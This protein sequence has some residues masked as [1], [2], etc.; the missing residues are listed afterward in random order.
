MITDRHSPK[1]ARDVSRRV[2]RGRR[3]YVYF[4]R[5][6]GDQEIRV[7]SL[8][9]KNVG[10]LLE[11][12]PRVV[13]YRAQPAVLELSTNQVVAHRNNFESQVGVK[14]QFYTPDFECVLAD[15]SVV[16][17]DAKHSVFLGEFEEKR[18]QIETCYGQRGIRFL[19]VSQ[20]MMSRELCENI[21][22]VHRVGA[23]YLASKVSAWTPKIEQLLLRHERWSVN[24]LAEQFV[25]GKVVVLAALMT[26]VLTTDFRQSLFSECATVTAGFGGLNHFEILN[27]V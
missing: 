4:S 7:E 13:S 1:F 16:V 20:D 22:S 23:T 8:I 14:P 2:H 5:K 24:E 17:I 10:M 26:G 21:E 25:E 27:Y 3:A 11:A 19:I 6:N 9:E 12:D 18:L 15:G